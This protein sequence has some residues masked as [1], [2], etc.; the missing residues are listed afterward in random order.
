M[1]IIHIEILP[2]FKPGDPAPEGYNQWHVWAELQ[3]KAGLRQKRCPQCLRF[4]FPHEEHECSQLPT[5]KGF[6]ESTIG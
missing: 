3:V 2:T 6:Y 5:P 1:N 4:Y